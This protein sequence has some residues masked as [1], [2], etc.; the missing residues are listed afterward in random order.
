MPTLPFESTTKASVEPVAMCKRPEG[1][2]VPMPS[3]R[4]VLSQ[5]RLELFWEIKPPVPAKGIEP[6]VRA[7]KVMFPEEVMPVAAVTAPVEFIWNW[8]LMPTL[9]RAEGEVVPIPVLPE[10][11]TNRASVVPVATLN[12]EVAVLESEY[13][14]SK[15]SGLDVPMPT[16]ESL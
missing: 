12:K 9:N 13:M 7:E 16:L 15:E 3:L 10:L 8:L 4:L 5:K 11:S 2:E 1:E 6:E 14:S